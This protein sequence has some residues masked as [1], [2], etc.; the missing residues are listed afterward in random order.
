ML[1]KEIIKQ[2]PS[3]TLFNWKQRDFNTLFGTDHVVF[4]D[5]KIQL[6]KAFM[7]RKQIYN[8]VKAMYK[9]YSAWQQLIE[10]SRD[11]KKI[12]R[13][14]K[15]IVVGT[16]NSVKDVFGLERAGLNFGIS[17]QQYYSWRE[18]ISCENKESIVCYKRFPGQ[19]SLADIESIKQ[20][21]TKE[22]LKYWSMGSVYYQMMRE[23][24]AYMSLSTFY[25]YARMLNLSRKKPKRRR[26]PNYEGLQTSRPGEA[27]HLDVSIFKTLDNTT[28]YL[29]FLA[30][31][32]SRFILG[33]RASLKYSSALTS[34]LMKEVYEKYRNHQLKL[35]VDLIV[36]DGVENK[37]QLDQ[38]LE[39]PLVIVNKYVAQKDIPF[40][41]SMVEA[42]NKRMK[43]DYL[44]TRDFTGFKHVLQYLNKYAISNYNNKPHSALF[45]L[46]PFEVFN[47]KQPDPF[48]FR[49]KIK[50][51]GKQRLI[52]NSGFKCEDCAPITSCK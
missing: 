50:E 16:I 44:F 33:W 30:D 18:E 40:S 39:N 17:T 26:S 45:G 24:A 23:G 52:T 10:R 2:I 29:Y 49:D 8:T 36:D 31:N 28:V 3:S 35:N 4:S 11:W 37:G 34:E 51:A 43:Y 32:F 1:D 20:Y 6:I 9:V 14:S 19:I 25:R 13:E 7:E 42:V 41:N 22:T 48:M 27:L 5:D 21:L 47:G 12:L 46:T 38:Y 15:E